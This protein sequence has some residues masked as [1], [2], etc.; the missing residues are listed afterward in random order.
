MTEETKRLTD[1]YNDLLSK[2][3]STMKKIEEEVKFNNAKKMLQ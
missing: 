2:K 3:K 1:E